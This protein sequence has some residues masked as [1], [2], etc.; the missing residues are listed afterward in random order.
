MLTVDDYG[1]IRR[2][3]RDGMS[4]REIARRLH[5]SRRKI[6]Q[7]LKEAQPRPYTR[8]KDPPAPKL[9]PFRP[10]IEQILAE[11]EKAPRKQ[12]HTAAQIYRRLRDENGYPGGY[13]SV[14]RYV[15]R[16]RK[17]HRQTFIPLVP[18]PG[19]RLE[20][21]F[22]HIHVDFPDGRRPVA[23]LLTTWSY[24]H[25]PFAM[26][27]PTERIEAILSG[28]VE[29]FEFFGCVPREVWWDNPKTVAQEIL[30]GRQRRLSPY[31]AA[32]ASHYTFEPLFCMPGAPHEKPRVEN[33]VYDLQRRWATPVPQVKDLAELNHLLRQRCLGETDRVVSGQTET[34][35]ERFRR[36]CRAAL[37]LPRHP[38]D[39]CIHQP[40]KVDKYQTVAF[41]KNRYSV[42]RRWAFET[43]TVKAYVERIEIVAAGQVVARYPRVYGR[44]E[45]FL[46][47][48]HYLVTLSRRPAA[49]DH[50]SVYRDWK[51]PPCFDRLR[52]ALEA[53]HG[54]PAGAREY[55]RVLQL[56]A[57]HPVARVAQA[58]ESG[59]KNGTPSAAMIRRQVHRMALREAPQSEPVE[60]LPHHPGINLQVPHPD[61]NR[62]N[63]LLSQG[64]PDHVQHQPA[65]EDQPEAAAAAH[66][67][68][69][70]CQVGP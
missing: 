22:G 1:R 25:F 7:V 19:Q 12:R 70:V 21:D 59:W 8:R 3:H 42:P 31:Y 20:A 69:G 50:S 38:F 37:P 45:Q 57:Q 53:C 63:Q 11:D 27:L 66:H 67:A 56:L 54:T 41:D 32:L 5:H 61:L 15:A 49:L 17:P 24:S 33:R 51:L 6:R 46:D 64:E 62:F 55:V 18:V 34:I 4:I 44:G 68:G 60:R 9:G 52:A 23:V 47:P 16:H 10:I 28:M 43:V 14:R 30:R 35:G 40:A 2:A 65:P 39:P 29:A 26:A 58:I 48:L 13:D 36:D